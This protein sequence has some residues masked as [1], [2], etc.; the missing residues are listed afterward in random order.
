MNEAKKGKISKK[1]KRISLITAAVIL[2]VGGG[3]GLYSSFFS[4]PT[5]PNKWQTKSLEGWINYYAAE[6]GFYINFP[7]I[8]IQESIELNHA[9]L[10]KPLIYNEYKTCNDDK[11]CYAI[12]YVDFPSKWKWAGSR[13]L[14]KGAL[15][16]MLQND[17]EMQLVSQGFTKHGSFPALDFHLTKGD[18][19]MEGRIVLVGTTLY[20]LT[21]AFPPSLSKHIG[22]HLFIESFQA[23]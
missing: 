21:V 6:K 15:E 5:A 17:G 9:R 20:K 4:S 12:G 10:K 11:L 19:E 8:P 3:L 16:M 2:S 18:K 22:P 1:I 13:T 14:L 7:V 23:S